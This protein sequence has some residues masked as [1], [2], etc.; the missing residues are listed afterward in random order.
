MTEHEQPVAYHVPIKPMLGRAASDPVDLLANLNKEVDKTRL[1][2][3]FKYDG[4]RSHIH[5]DG[6]RVSLFSRS[7]D[8]QNLKF[9]QLHEQLTKDLEGKPKF[10]AD[11]EVVYVD[12]DGNLLPF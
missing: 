11:G 12:F 9:W 4:E 10:I 7:C 1:S 6:T 3:E 2:A 5:F 8:T